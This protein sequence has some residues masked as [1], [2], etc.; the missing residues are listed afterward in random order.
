MS[1]I[2][3]LPPEDFLFFKYRAVNKRLLESLVS[4]KLYFSKPSQLNDPFDCLLDLKK[5]FKRAASKATGRRKEWLEHALRSGDKF[6]SDFHT[7]FENYG[8]CSFSLDVRISLMWSH[9]ADEHRG[10]CLLYRFKPP[11]FW[12]PKNKIFG[13]TKV[14]YQDDVLTDWLIGD[15]PTEMKAFTAELAKRYLTAK[16]PGWHYEKEARVIRHT[17]GELAVPPGCLEQV[18]FGLRTP[19]S[20][21]HLVT[22]LASK[23]SGCKQFGQMHRDENDF[24]IEARDL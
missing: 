21:I 5:S 18:C 6:L 22:E 14:E 23:Y 1:S 2:P 17:E 10:V 9:Y 24:G 16:A 4:S 15:A 8:I 11:Y 20:D 13:V 12:E 7:L 3:E 19:P